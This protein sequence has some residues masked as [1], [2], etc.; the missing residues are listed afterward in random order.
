MAFSN[1]HP[2]IYNSFYTTGSHRATAEWR[3]FE[4]GDPS[5]LI[6]HCSALSTHCSSLQN[7]KFQDLTPE[8]PTQNRACAIFTEALPSD[9]HGPEKKHPPKI[10]VIEEA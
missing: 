5:S 8:L 9:H 6:A 10:R 7:A 3:P 2:R 1:P 4:N